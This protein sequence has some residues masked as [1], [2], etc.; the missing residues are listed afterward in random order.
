MGTSKHRSY[1][2][3]W[4]A[5]RLCILGT[6]SR[7]WLSCIFWNTPTISSGSIALYSFVSSVE[8]T[9][10]KK[11]FILKELMKSYEIMK[12][13]TWFL[14]VFSSRSITKLFF[15]T[16]YSRTCLQVHFFYL[17][18]SRYS[19]HQDLLNWTHYGDSKLFYLEDL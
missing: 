2:H 3:I 13:K 11:K 7:Y 15:R 14:V 8:S 10:R 18:S 4:I 12:N 5:L 16:G 19:L 17:A 1:W 6:T 9:F